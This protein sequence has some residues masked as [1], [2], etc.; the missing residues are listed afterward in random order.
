[1]PAL[2]GLSVVELLMLQS[3][4]VAELRRRGIART[5]NNPIGDY[6][7]HICCKAFGWQQ[8]GNSAKDADAIGSDGARYQVK[9]RRVISATRGSRQLSAIRR[10]PDRGFDF[11]AGVIFLADFSVYRA[12]L[13]PHAVVGARATHIPATNSW[14]FYLRDDVWSLPGVQDITAHLRA[15][16]L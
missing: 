15:V 16:V 7:E 1:M 2:D 9:G 13:I 5:A 8:A 6:T 11:I 4:A 3:D 12:A 14:K 10:L